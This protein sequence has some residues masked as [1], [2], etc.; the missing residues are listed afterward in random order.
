LRDAN[1]P[2]L[3]NFEPNSATPGTQEY[4]RQARIFANNQT[5]VSGA[6]TEGNFVSDGD[7]IKL[8]EVSVSYNFS[9]LINRLSPTSAIDNMTLS[10]SARNIFTVTDYTGYDPEVNFTGGEGNIQGQDFL[11]LPQPRTLTAS[12]NLRF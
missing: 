8:R 2:Y 1:L 9:D 12:I 3:T 5:S 10:L 11:T 7:Y 6:A 4:V